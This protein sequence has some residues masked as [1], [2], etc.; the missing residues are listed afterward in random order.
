MSF[1]YTTRQKLEKLREL[2]RSFD[3]QAYLIPSEDAH[4]SEYIAESD[5][6]R[7]FISHFTG[8]AGY[9]IVT[10][11]SAALWTDGRYFLQAQHELDEN[12]TL[13]KAGVTGVPSKEQWLFDQLESGNAVGIDA[14]LVTLGEFERLS[15]KLASKSISVKLVE[16]NLVDAIWKTR[17][18]RPANAIFP[19]PV[20]FAGKEAAHKVSQLA[21][22]IRE[23]DCAFGVFTALDEI[24]WLL[25]ARGSDI[26]FNPVFFAFAVVKAC[27]EVLLFASS[28]EV[29]LEES[30]R[31]VVTIKPYASFLE[32]IRLLE[33][34]GKRILLPSSAASMSI[35]Q[36]VG[37]KERILLLPTSP[38]C[39]QKAVKNNVEIEGFRAC[40]IRD[41]AAL[42]AFFAWLNQEVAVKGNTELNEVSVADK[43]EEFR[44]KQLHYKGLSFPTIS[45]YASNGAVIHYTPSLQTAAKISTDSLYLCDS[46]GQYLDGTTDVTRT[47]YFGTCASQREREAYTLVLQGHINLALATFPKGTSGYK[48]DA[49]ARLPLW[50]AGL[51]Y[52][53]GTGHGVGHFLCVHEGPQGISYRIANNEVALEPGMT[54]TNEPGYYEAGA[55]GIR[56]EN[57]MVVDWAKTRHS[58]NNVEFY[59]FETVTR[60]P[61]AR[62]LI[63][64]EMLSRVQLRWL[65]AYHKRVREVLEPLL[66]EDEVALQ[67][68][69]EQTQEICAE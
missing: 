51:D 61:Y 12:W 68:L 53:H 34:E 38:I 41:G 55:F 28:S 59:N 64:V 3:V 10:E 37:G 30:V 46:G 19:L 35:V 43:L 56:L 60:V 11:K 44:S 66:K 25:N 42:T 4:Q 69:S 6:R 63:A 47:L 67:W 49:I 45:A 40:H 1:H 20:A 27:G 48:L 21:A 14:T 18:Q 58:F 17:S 26:S 13:M 5:A 33:T 24:C 9:A 62:N 2:M 23:H 7:A 65:N 57:V 29:Q 8:S 32:H 16:G 50:N 31:A 39:M 52:L 54:V 22:V 36:A 15:G